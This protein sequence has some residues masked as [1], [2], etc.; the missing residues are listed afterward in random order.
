MKKLFCSAML[1]LFV[2]YTGISQTSVWKVTTKNSTLYLGGTIHLLRSKDFPLP[3]PFDSAY[4]KSD[5][6]VFEADL[7]SMEKPETAQKLAQKLMYTDERTLKTELSDTA[8][9][10]LENW[11][12][13][14]G[15]PIANM[16][17]FKPSMVVL[18]VGMLK[19]QQMGFSSNGVDKNYFNLAK[20]DGKKM[21]F[22]ETVDQQIDFIANM[23]GG[24]DSDFVLYTLEDL[25]NTEKEFPEMVNA[26][27]NG[28][29]A[30]FTSESRDMKKEYPQV[31][32]SLVFNRNNN[33]MP[34]IESFLKTPETEFILVGSLHLYGPDGIIKMLRDKGYQ[35]E[36]L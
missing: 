24:N 32:Q 3:A 28:N 9:H 31:Y 23:S 35:V 8:Y 13:I 14:Y 36:Q 10:T 4:K 18:M 15:I 12:K 17:K 7:E 19:M 5:M 27:R 2:V 33:W 20:Q 26:W 21:S 22:F 25:K 1:I 6:V 11:C 30:L 29:D 16:N 34:V